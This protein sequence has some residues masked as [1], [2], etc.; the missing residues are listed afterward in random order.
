MTIRCK[1]IGIEQFELMATAQI[2]YILPNVCTAN[3]MALY[4]IRTKRFSWFHRVDN[5]HQM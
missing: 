3:C 4:A 2:Q 5:G 1:R